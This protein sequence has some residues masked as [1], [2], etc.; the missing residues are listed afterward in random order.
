MNSLFPLVRL[1][2]LLSFSLLFSDKSSEDIQENINEE[3]KKAESLEYEI[4]TLADEIKNKDIQSKTTS[5]KLAAIK[6]KI[7]LVGD[8]IDLL[9]K[10]EKNLSKSIRNSET[11]INQKESEL[12]ELKDKFSK[13]I[14]YLYK[15]KS[16]NYLDILL[17]SKNWEDMVYKVKYL[18]VIS[19]QHKKVKND[20]QSVINELDDEILA[21]TNQLLDKKNKR[22]N[23]SDTISNLA[24][25]NDG[26]EQNL[27]K[28]REEK[29]NLE[30]DRNKKKTA[31]VQINELIEKLYVNRDDAKKREKKLKKIREEKRKKEIEAS[32]Q[33]KEFSAMKG[34]LPWP[35]EGSII[36]NFGIERNKDGL[37]AKKLWIEMRTKK[38]G[39]VK[40]VFDGIVS[41]I[42]YNPVYNTY[43]IIEHGEGYST[44]YA[45]LD[46]KS[47]QISIEDYIDAET[48]IANTLNISNS[49]KKSYGLLY[50]MVFGMKNNSELITYNPREWIK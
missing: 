38:N 6:E 42:D 17:S 33:N 5:N 40:A 22:K 32:K 2:L 26:E 45:N 7:E 11:R 21:L 27:K 24:K 10:D 48:I 18:E 36:D 43:I 37:K 41:K 8:L 23:K 25:K 28:I 29:F 39:E 50:F 3:N 46:D 34:N 1:L 44:L 14:L 16:D 35:V 20:I 9:K 47:I 30:K 13:M 31:L 4:N 19:Y 12:N 15:S 49:K